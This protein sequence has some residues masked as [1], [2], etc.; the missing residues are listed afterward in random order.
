MIRKL[1]LCMFLLSGVSLAAIRGPAGSIPIGGMMSIMP[2][3]S[4]TWQPPLAGGVKDGFMLADGKQVLDTSSP[5]Y[6]QYLP[7][8]TGSTYVSGHT[9]SSNIHA[10]ANLFTMG[11][12]NLPPHTHT[13]THDHA[14][15]ATGNPSANHTHS[16][17]PPATTTNGCY[18]CT[19]YFEYTDDN[20]TSMRV[21]VKSASGMFSSTNITASYLNAE[22][23]P[24]AILDSYRV[25][26]TLP[27]H[28]HYDNPGAYPSGTVSAW[29]THS[30]NLPNFVGDSGY[31]GSGDDINN[32]PRNL[33]AVWIVRVK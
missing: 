32:E 12:A 19:G 3:I 33:A 25:N 2:H 20:S 21:R 17:N 6:G 30:V 24:S 5:M 14:N 31:T 23:V 22:S 4:G 28:T 10:G 9:T 7:D 26:I 16:F 11:T 18:N 27:T 29:H 8:M 13:A 15:K 1:L